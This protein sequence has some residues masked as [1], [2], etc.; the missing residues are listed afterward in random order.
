[1]DNEQHGTLYGLYETTTDDEGTVLVM[2]QSPLNHVFYESIDELVDHISDLYEY[3]QQVK[4]WKQEVIDEEKVL[5]VDMDGEW[6][7][8]WECGEDCECHDEWCGCGEWEWKSLDDED[9]TVGGTNL[10]H[11]H[12]KK[13]GCCGGHCSCSH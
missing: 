11:H 13:E 10:G 3:T 2:W 4:S 9:G 5:F 7:D 8:E 1:M 12:E 6:E